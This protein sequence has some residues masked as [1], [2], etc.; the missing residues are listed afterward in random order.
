MTWP[1]LFFGTLVQAIAV[2]M[3]AYAMYTERSAT[4]FGMMALVGFGTG[5][6]FMSAP[7]HGVGIFRK[8]RAS[9][10]GL[11]SVAFPLGGTIGLTIMSTVFNNTSRFDSDTNFS[12]IRELPPDLQAEYKRSAKMGIVWAFVAITPFL[13]LAWFCTFFLGNV[14][15]G[16]GYGPDEEGTQ[17]TIIEDVYLLT[18]IRGR[19][20]QDTSSAVGDGEAAQGSTSRSQAQPANEALGRPDGA[21]S[22]DG[23]RRIDSSERP[24]L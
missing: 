18:L 10:I 2:G 20:S 23:H 6:R 14:K 22:A 8:H 1:T 17:N 19:R 15:L 3:L 11:L 21:V 12:T 7:L 13:L 9:V 4:V 5:L 16:R 24:L